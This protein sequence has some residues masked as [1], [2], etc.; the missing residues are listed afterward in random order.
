MDK[1]IKPPEEIQLDKLKDI[2][3]EHFD[4]YLLIVTKDSK[5]WNTYSSKTS[6]F[7][8]AAMVMSDIEQDWKKFRNK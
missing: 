2:A 8:M 6:A 7:G 4:G 5:I 1:A 3:G